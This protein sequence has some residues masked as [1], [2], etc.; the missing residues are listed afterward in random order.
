VQFNF[1]RA[2]INEDYDPAEKL[3]GFETRDQAQKG[4]ACWY[5]LFQNWE[6]PAAYSHRDW[7]TAVSRNVDQPA[8]PCASAFS[9]GGGARPLRNTWL[10]ILIIGSR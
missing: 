1:F 9:G 8:A 3:P 7:T 10:V 5:P 2:P 4:A 6:K